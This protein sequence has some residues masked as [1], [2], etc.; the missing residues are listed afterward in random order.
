[1]EANDHA[2]ESR[3]IRAGLVR[4]SSSV[5][6]PRLPCFPDFLSGPICTTQ[7][8]AIT[9]S[10]TR[11]W[12]IRGTAASRRPAASDMPPH[13]QVDPNDQWPLQS[14]EMER[15]NKTY[16]NSG[17][18]VYPAWAARGTN[19]SWW[20]GDLNVEFPFYENAIALGQPLVC[21][22]QGRKPTAFSTRTWIRRTSG[23]FRGRKQSEHQF[24]SS[25]TQRSSFRQHRGCVMIAREIDGGRPRM[26]KLIRTVEVL[27]RD[28]GQERV[29]GTSRHR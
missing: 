1:M 23:P 28:Q 8:C 24:S 20:M 14:E 5:A 6:T 15:I 13:C 25:I 4:R 17:W 22:S 21:A 19:D 26:D 29:R 9:R 2:P 16:G 27:E 12:S 11:T 7:R 3:A 18:K 10:R